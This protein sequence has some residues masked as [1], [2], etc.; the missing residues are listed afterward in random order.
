MGTRRRGREARQT[1]GR[2][3]PAASPAPRAGLARTIHEPVACECR[4]PGPAFGRCP[5]CV[6]GSARPCDVSPTRLRAGQASALRFAG[7][8]PSRLTV[9]E[10]SGLAAAAQLKAPRWR[11]GA[12]ARDPAMARHETRPP[13]PLALG[14]LARAP[15]YFRG[16]VTTRA[17]LMRPRSMSVLAAFSASPAVA[18]RPSTTRYMVV[19]SSR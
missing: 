19:P 16:I 10:Q 15:R 1:R 7:I 5:R 14:G 2:A 4:L 13:R 12:D 8:R 17:S 3:A 6:E 11:R 18:Q 9:H